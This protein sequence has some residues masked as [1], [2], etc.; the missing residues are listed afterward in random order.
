MEFWAMVRPDMGPKPIWPTF[1]LSL[2]I[3]LLRPGAGLAQNEAFIHSALLLTPASH[4]RAIHMSKQHSLW[5]PLIR[6]HGMIL[7]KWPSHLNPR[8]P[9]WLTIFD[10]MRLLQHC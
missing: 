8:R 10:Q 3:G 1:G 9:L 2:E 4:F 5:Q 6:H 7:A